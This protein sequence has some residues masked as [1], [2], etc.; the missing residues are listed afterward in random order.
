VSDAR[1]YDDPCGIAR[2]LDVIGD[3][4]ALLVV[5]ELTFG[6]RRFVAL[7]AGL[8]GISP[9]VLAQRLRGLEAAGVVRRD[10]LGPPASVAVYELTDRG[11]E[12][13]PVLLALGRWGS[14]EPVTTPAELSVSAL[15]VALQ[16]VYAPGAAGAPAAGTAFALGFDGDWYQVAAS[17]DGLDITPGRAGQPAA[18]LEAD[19]ATMRAVAFGR[20]PAGAA[21]RAG[22]LRITGDRRAADSFASMFAL[23]RSPA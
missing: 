3:R 19:V 2:A 23:A 18:T 12:L 13:R 6:P 14:G 16:T 22:R 4:W 15:L 9:N 10:M 5:R 7:R 21:E 11:R 1:R 8:H 17:E 20:E